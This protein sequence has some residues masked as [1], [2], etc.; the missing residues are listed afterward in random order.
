[1]LFREHFP[2]P[3]L[4]NYI[5]C[6][7]TLKISG[8]A[9][10]YE[11][12]HFLVENVEF[13][14]NLSEE[15]KFITYDMKTS[16]FPQCCVY[17]PMTQA[18]HLKPVSEVEIFGICFRPGGAY[19]FFPYPISEL[20]NSFVTIDD[21]WE[22][23][24]SEIIHKLHHDCE[25]TFERI[26]LLDQYF[27]RHL[28]TKRKDDSIFAAVSIIEAYKGQ[29]NIEY[30]ARSIGQSRRQLERKFKERV[31]ISPKQ[32]CRSLRFKNVL[33]LL[34]TSSNVSWA[35]TAVSSG[36]YDQSHMIRDFKHYM[37]ESPL[38]YLVTS[39]AMD[40]YFT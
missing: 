6:Y 32:L 19:P 7:W 12:L 16:V 2:H 21:L 14:F 17:G 26:D 31:G 25:T 37:G 13:T 9:Q 10:K 20:V 1:M 30:V 3:K 29:V 8:S 39:K 23:N 15:A 34:N 18:M 40:R 38:A 36:Y 24:N 22:A 28:D 33:R 35:S 4:I 5:R 11:W 27:L